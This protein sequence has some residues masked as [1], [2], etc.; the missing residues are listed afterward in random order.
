M[1]QGFETLFKGESRCSGHLE[2][3]FLEQLQTKTKTNIIYFD[4]HKL[5]ITD[6]GPYYQV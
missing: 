4:P 5:Q 2:R 6:H 1:F 3:F